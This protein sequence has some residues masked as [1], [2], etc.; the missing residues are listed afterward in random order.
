MFSREYF[1][2]KICL[3]YGFQIFLDAQNSNIFRTCTWWPTFSHIFTQIRSSRSRVFFKKSYSEVFHIIHRK[4]PVICV[5]YIA[6]LFQ[7]YHLALRLFVFRADQHSLFKFILC[8][9]FS[10]VVFYGRQVNL[11]P[12][13]S[14]LISRKTNLISI[15]LHATV[16]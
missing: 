9:F 4:T 11:T 14:L 6:S 1:L 5:D 12:L 15:Q 8:N 10:K 13:T 7:A 2:P 3:K 16:K